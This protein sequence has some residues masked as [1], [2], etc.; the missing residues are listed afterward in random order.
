[1]WNA[2]KRDVTVCAQK[3]AKLFFYGGFVVKVDSVFF[4]RLIKFLL[5]VVEVLRVCE[6]YKESK[7]RE[8]E[9]DEKKTEGVK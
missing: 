8:G 3:K 4:G 9:K 1:M 7:E 2:R 5:G 6:S